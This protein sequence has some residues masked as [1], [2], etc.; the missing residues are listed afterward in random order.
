MKKLMLI[1]L[2]IIA[3]SGCKGVITGKEYTDQDILRIAAFSG[4]SVERV[5]FALSNPQDVNLTELA[6]SL[7]RIERAEKEIKG[8][9]G[10]R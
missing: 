10:E 4:E 3:I 1:T 2:A 8:L 9:K 7:E 6:K 5:K